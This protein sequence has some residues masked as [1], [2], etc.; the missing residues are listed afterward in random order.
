MRRKSSSSKNSRQPIPA[1]NSRHGSPTK[2][3]RT[4]QRSKNSQASPEPKNSRQPNPAKNSP[5][6]SPAKNSRP[7]GEGL[8]RDPEALA[9]MWRGDKPDASGGNPES[10]H[11]GS[12]EDI[13]AQLRQLK[14]R[15]R[16]VI[17]RGAAVVLLPPVVLCIPFIVLKA[18]NLLLIPWPWCFAP[19]LL[20]L[21]PVALVFRTYIAAV[22]AFRHYPESGQQAS[23]AGAE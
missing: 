16:A 10:G 13:A 22:K 21:F 2:N 4:M 19:L 17:W 7:E 14:R 12:V 6:G 5:S 20:L 9:A 15:R 18:V 11:P 3:S 23:N 8:T 1:K